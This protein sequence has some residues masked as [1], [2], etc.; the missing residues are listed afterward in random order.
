MLAIVHM[1]TQKQNIIGD[2]PCHHSS[3]NN[4][5]NNSTE[6]EIYTKT[7][8]LLDALIGVIFLAFLIRLVCFFDT[9]WLVFY[10]SIDSLVS[11]PR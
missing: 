4:N 5:I 3:F 7:I 1:T 11:V 2:H 8:D 6:Y 10:N 9:I